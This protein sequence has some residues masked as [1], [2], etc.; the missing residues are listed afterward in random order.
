MLYKRCMI[1]NEVSR[2]FAPYTFV[3][4]SHEEAIDVGNRQLME[5]SD[6]DEDL[7]LLAKNGADFK[8]Q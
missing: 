7:L 4:P 8:S 5:E 2:C 6:E 1:P 3:L